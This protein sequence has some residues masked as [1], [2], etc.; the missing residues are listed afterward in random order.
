MKFNDDDH[1][2]GCTRKVMDLGTR[3]SYLDAPRERRCRL[4]SLA[5]RALEAPLETEHQTRMARIVLERLQRELIKLEHA[6]VLPPKK[7]T[8]G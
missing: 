5:D 6:P 1:W 4:G 2:L 7:G 8:Q 3:A